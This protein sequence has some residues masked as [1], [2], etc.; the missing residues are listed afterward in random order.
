MTHYTNDDYIDYLHGELAPAADARLHAHLLACEPCRA[1]YEAEARLGEW[2][3][4]AAQAD[5]RE[6]PSLV[7]ARVWEAVRNARP[8]PAQRLRAFLRPVVTVPAGVA[9][10]A[11]VFV[12]FPTLHGSSGSAPV[13]TVS[14]SYYLDE[15]AAEGQANPL[16][17]HPVSASVVTT[18]DTSSDPAVAAAP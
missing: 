8:S 14:A 3:R 15:H 18:S 17:D 1:G 4:S 9:F 16:A 11:L 10:A 7:K 12:A 13:P 6:L 2:V 5:E